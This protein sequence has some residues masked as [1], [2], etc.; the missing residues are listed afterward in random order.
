MGDLDILAQE[1]DCNKIHN[2][3][4]IMH[5]SPVSENH[6]TRMLH[7]S[8]SKVVNGEVVK[9]QTSNV[10]KSKN[11]TIYFY[12]DGDTIKEIGISITDSLEESLL[13]SDIISRFIERKML[14]LL[15][16][17]NLYS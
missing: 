6:R 8:F 4:K 7:S 3:L 10:V 2:I 5:Y 12:M 13:K 14:E 16:I 15:L 11:A 9:I 1:Q 17:N